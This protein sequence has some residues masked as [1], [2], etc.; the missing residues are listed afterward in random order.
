M[1]KRTP[2]LRPSRKP[3]IGAIGCT[4]CGWLIGFVAYLVSFGIRGDGF[5]AQARHAA[6]LQGGTIGAVLGLLI[7]FAVYWYLLEGYADPREWAVIFALTSILTT[8]IAMLLPLLAMVGGPVSTLV[9]AA[10]VKQKR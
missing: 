7:G 1:R 8:L 5:G 4:A 10:W 6:M 3:V 2:R 9:G